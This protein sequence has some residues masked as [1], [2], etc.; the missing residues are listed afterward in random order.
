MED[1]DYIDTLAKSELS[2]REAMPSKDGWSIVQKKLA[3]KRKR[4]RLLLFLLLFIAVGSI[5]VY[6]V[7]HYNT[8]VDAD[9]VVNT[10]VEQQKTET[11]E[12]SKTPIVVDTDSLSNSYSVSSS[13]SKEMSQAEKDALTKNDTTQ[14]NNN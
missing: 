5:G 6:Q 14:R 12:N 3:R 1:F 11:P 2:G 4:R 8:T 10:N 13:N 7:I 9:S